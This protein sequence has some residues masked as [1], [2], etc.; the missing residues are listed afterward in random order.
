MQFLTTGEFAQACQISIPTVK[1]WI[2]EGHL[3]AF[4]T[5]GGHYRITEQEFK[6]FKLASGM[7]EREEGR[8]RIL[9]IEDDQVLCDE[10]AEALSWDERYEVEAAG[11][12]Y[13]G[14][15]KVGTFFPHLLILDLRMP[16]LD[17]FQVCKRVK[18]DPVTRSIKVLAIT[19]YPEHNARERILK[20]GADIFLEKPIQLVKL[21]AEVAQ[22]LGVLRV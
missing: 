11:E 5:A 22:L 16:G 18:G 8:P 17:G 13:G 21:Q 10:M 2:R 9:I 3:A 19:A 4:R 15:I 20:M 1:R 7:P 6:R 14:L 12:G